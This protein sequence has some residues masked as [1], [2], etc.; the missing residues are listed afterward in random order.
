MKRDT[1]KNGFGRENVFLFKL[2]S[3][4]MARFVVVEIYIVRARRGRGDYEREFIQTILDSQKTLIGKLYD[5]ITSQ[6]M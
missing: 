5:V 6:F 3:K 4:R 2:F 1:K